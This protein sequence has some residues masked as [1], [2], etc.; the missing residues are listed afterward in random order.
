MEIFSHFVQENND[1]VVTD[2]EVRLVELVGYVEA[3]ALEFSAFQQDGVEP[4]QGEEQLA[5]TESLPAPAEL[6]LSIFPFDRESGRL[7]F[8]SG[9]AQGRQL[10]LAMNMT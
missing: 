3:E 6:F 10:L 9:G 5:V 1:E 2:A 8:C 7:H 4:G